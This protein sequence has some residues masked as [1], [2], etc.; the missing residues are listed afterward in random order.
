MDKN[1][2]AQINRFVSSL[3]QM[4]NISGS[5]V[6]FTKVAQRMHLPEALPGPVKGLVML[7]DMV[8]V[9]GAYAGAFAMAVRNEDYALATQIVVNRYGCKALAIGA[10][11]AASSTVIAMASTGVAA[12]YA[13]PP[14]GMAATAGTAITA[15]FAGMTA[16]NATESACS[17]IMDKMMQN[18]Q[19]RNQFNANMRVAIQKEEGMLDWISDSVSNTTTEA[20]LGLQKVLDPRTWIRPNPMDE[21][22]S[23]R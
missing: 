11:V 14:A 7:A 1:L 16:Y 8:G 22:F 9:N 13:V 10:S 23:R 3:D 18:P 21:T 15:V 4:D 12:S 5:A 2:S 20:A 19:W 17:N 6:Y